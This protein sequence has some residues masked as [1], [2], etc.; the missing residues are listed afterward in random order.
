MHR[1]AFL[2]N[3]VSQRKL[4][5]VLHDMCC[6]LGMNRSMMNRGMMNGGMMNRSMMNRSMM[7][8]CVTGKDAAVS[9]ACFF[10]YKP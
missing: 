9:C 5:F 3:R 4:S 10:A 7:N 6:S 1:D 2:V 8:R